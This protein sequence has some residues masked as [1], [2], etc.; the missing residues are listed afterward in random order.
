MTDFAESITSRNVGLPRATDRRNLSELL[1]ISV[2][3]AALAIVLVFYAWVRCETVSMGYEQHMLRE[4][5]RQLEK[6]RALLV[7]QEE[8]LKTPERLERIAREELGMIP[9]SA[10][11]ILP[12]GPADLEPGGSTKLALADT[13]G[14]HSQPRRIGSSY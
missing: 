7:V 13:G 10:S 14:A 5:E 8:T 9:L 11:Q 12:P 4:Q 6:Q 2:S 1:R 3:L